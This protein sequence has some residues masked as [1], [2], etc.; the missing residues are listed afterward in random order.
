MSPAGDIAFVDFGA[1]R[2]A[3]MDAALETGDRGTLPFVAPEVARG[4]AAPSQAA[5]V[6][7]LATTI[8][9]L[10]TGGDLQVRAREEAAMLLE[11][12]ERGLPTALCDRAIG[13]SPA[14]RDALRRAIALDPAARPRTSRELWRAFTE[15]DWT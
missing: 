1:A 14:G 3:G 7:A 8:L 5:D 6:Y 10:A 15:E 13:L 2:F 12:G 9:F 11:I 4:E